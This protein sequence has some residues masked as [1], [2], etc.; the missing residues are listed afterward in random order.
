MNASE[1]GKERYETFHRER[2]INKT[3]KLSDTI[4]RLN[5]KTM[6]TI[7]NKPKK[8]TKKVIRG[9]NMT[10]KAIEVARDRGL[11][12]EDLLTYEVA[13]STM[14]SDDEGLMIKPK[15]SQLIHELVD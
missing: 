13:S 12:T 5:L 6:I 9:I 1:K 4:H 15:K 8:T 14:L 2:I 3:M 7:R 11:T 10:E